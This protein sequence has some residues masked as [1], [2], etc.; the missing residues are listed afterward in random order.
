MALGDVRLKTS[1]MRL[2]PQRRVIYEYAYRIEA[3]DPKAEL[4]KGDTLVISWSDFVSLTTAAE[5]SALVSVNNKL[6]AHAKSEIPILSEALD[7]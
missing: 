1:S 6:K 3:K 2:E 5:R 7:E 4:R